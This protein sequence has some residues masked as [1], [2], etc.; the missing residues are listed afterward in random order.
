MSNINKIKEYLIDLDIDEIKDISSQL[1]LNTQDLDKYNLIK[2]ILKRFKS[3]EKK[4]SRY[5]KIK[6]LGNVGKEGTTYLVENE[7]KHLYA[8]KQFKSTKSSTNIEKEAELQKIAANYD[9][10]PRIYEVNLEQKF[11]VMEKLDINLCQ[12]LKQNNGELTDNIQL[13]II[14]IINK[15]DDIGVFHGDPNPSNFMIHNGKVYIIDFGFSKKIDSQLIEKYTDKPNKNFMVLGL[16]LKLRE[17][18]GTRKYDIFEKYLP[19]DQKK[20]FQI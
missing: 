8:M 13:H 10:S 19:E 15:L 14:N 11:I 2:L 12:I 4:N 1:D 6:Q 18:F 16:V 5:N 3:L 9:L 20:M 17:M 7:D